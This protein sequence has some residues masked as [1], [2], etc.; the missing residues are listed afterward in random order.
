M[1]LSLLSIQAQTDSTIILS[2]DPTI[3]ILHT[4]SY[5]VYDPGGAGNYNPNTNA[6]LTL[7]SDG[8]TPFSLCGTVNMPCGDDYVE[9]YDG[10]SSANGVLLGHYSCMNEII[11]IRCN[12]GSCFIF[13]HSS[14]TG[15]GDGFKFFVNFS[16]AYDIQASDITNNSAYITWSDSDPTVTQWTIIYGTSNDDLDTVYSTTPYVTLDSLQT[17]SQYNI[18]I[19]QST[20]SNDICKNVFFTNCDVYNVHADCISDTC[21]VISFYTY[22][23]DGVW[24]ITLRDGGQT[25]TDTIFNVTNSHHI[26]DTICNLAPNTDYT[27]TI[28]NSLYESI[29]FCPL[30]HFTTPAPSSPP[31]EDHVFNVQIQ[32]SS[33]NVIVNF[34]DT[35]QGA[36]TWT[37]H[38][39][40]Y[41]RN[42]DT[43]IHSRHFVIENLIPNYYYSFTIKDNIHENNPCN[44]N[45]RFQTL[46]EMDNIIGVT[47]DSITSHS[48]KI[49]W[50]DN[51][52]DIHSW[53][54]KYK[55]DNA[56]DPNW[57]YFTCDTTSV[58]LNNLD[59]NY[60][61]TF[62]IYD[63]VS[64]NVDCSIHYYHF[65]IPCME[66][67]G[68]V[69]YTEVSSC[70]VNPTFGTVVSPAL[71]NGA[72]D[73]GS[74]SINSR[75]TVNYDT[76]ATDPRTCNHLKLIPN[77]HISSVR[78]GNWNAG[79]EA[80][81][82]TYELTVDTTVSD[83]II[84]RYAAV[85]E[86]PEHNSYD[87]P[88]F[89]MQILNDNGSVIDA[90]CYSKSF[91][92]DTSLGWNTCYYH[93]PN[94][95]DSIHYVLWKDWQAVSLDLSPFNGQKIYIRL[96]TYDCRRGAHFG[97]A[98]FTLDCSKKAISVTGCGD[99]RDNV[100][101]APE[102]FTYQWYKEDE[103][104]NILSTDRSFHPTETGDY[105]CKATFI[106]TY[107]CFMLI[108]AKVVNRYPV[109]NFNYDVISYKDCKINVQFTNDSFVA[110]DSLLLHLINDRCDSSMW[111]IYSIDH[112][113]TLYS[114]A[115]SYSFSAG[116][117]NVKLI[118]SINNGT[119]EDSVENVLRLQYPNTDTII[120][121]AI[122]KNSYYN[123]NG[124]ELNSSG[125]YVDTLSTYEGCDSVVTLKL[126]V[127]DVFYDTIYDTIE[128]GSVYRENGF[129]ESDPGVYSLYLTTN[130]GCDSIVTLFLDVRDILNVYLPNAF[131]PRSNDDKNNCFRIYTDYDLARV[132]E[133][134][135]YNRWGECMWQTDEVTDCWNGIYNGK[136]VPQG[137]YVYKLIYYS[138]TS[139]E[140]LYIKKGSL[141][142]I[143]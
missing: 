116:V 95:A 27:F 25:I 5:I 22:I 67:I 118:S 37:V 99:G 112:I 74:D 43:I 55:N 131:M 126:S 83:L 96:T 138:R 29:I 115:P 56:L 139:P 94:I 97:Y 13:F 123:F 49:S 16:S 58:I 73:Y 90:H 119:C 12:S 33:N 141:E 77:N 108:P 21:C 128:S 113:D 26:S 4:H 127:Y 40:G 121:K 98:Y 66:N 6:S 85:L 71:H 91:V 41:G 142:V 84:L 7:V 15:G 54:I 122:C 30:D 114:F 34:S 51:L 106:G 103:P 2:G 107:D 48:A 143:Y 50:T 9:V 44:R 68:C 101:T 61:Y 60:N 125:V 81:S 10:T 35:T 137:N 130:N 46:C 23:T 111:I 3:N 17:N 78:L 92:S 59:E 62:T 110:D 100:F 124:K 65:N 134:K 36:N 120:N 63:S 8:N 133:F 132:K 45:Y 75:H 47:V 19:N 52:D 14:A 136:L 86:N 38:F 102:G 72:V 20:T 18:Y 104:L 64:V 42:I 89:T 135:I 39:R 88:K 117:Y 129:N 140:K 11:N 28:N 105:I 87:Q 1:I 57:H 93:D 24:S 79:A 76:N 109:A 80:E 53:T 69:N 32:A 82:I 31:C 70:R